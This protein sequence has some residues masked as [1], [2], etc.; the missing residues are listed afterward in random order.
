MRTKHAQS[1][2][3]MAHDPSMTAWG[4]SVLKAGKVIDRGCIKTEPKH[5][6]LRTRKGDDTCRRISEIT[7]MLLEKVQEHSVNYFLSELPHGSQ[8]ASAAI[9]IGIVTGIAQTIADTLGIGIEWYS[10]GDSKMNALGKHSASKD[11][12]IQAMD[13]LYDVE[14]FGIK[15]KDEAV[16]DALAIHAIA[17]KQSS[18]LKLFR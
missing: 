8:S 6:K 4:W 7:Q 18:T 3:V 12:M 2:V 11:E 1:L 9:M 10:E 15:Y 17:L 13:T 5:K 16:A 14:W